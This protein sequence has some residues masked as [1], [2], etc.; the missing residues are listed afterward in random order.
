MNRTRGIIAVACTLI[1]LTTGTGSVPGSN[2]NSKENP[3]LLPSPSDSPPNAVWRWVAQGGGGGDEGFFR[4]AIDTSGNSYVTGV[5]QDSATF[6]K[7]N[8]TSKGAEDV[9]IAKMNAFGFWEWAVSAGGVGQD[10]GEGIVVD[11]DGTLYVVGAFAGT[12]TFGGFQLIS[13][14]SYDVFIAKLTNQGLWQWAISAGGTNEDSG[15]S[16]AIDGAGNMYITGGFRGSAIFGGTILT[17]SIDPEVYVA[18]ISADG[19]WQWAVAGNGTSD[20]EGVDIAVDTTAVYVLGSFDGSMT[21]GNITLTGTYDV[22]VACLNTSG[23]WQWASRGGGASF[24]SPYGFSLD[25][26][27]QAFVV[28]SFELTASFGNANITSLGGDDA[29]VAKIA[30]NGSW[31]WAVSAGGSGS[32]DQARSVAVDSSGNA[33]ISGQFQDT[34]GFGGILLTSVGSSDV[35]V[36]KLS[37]GGSWRW[38]SRAGSDAFDMGFGVAVE[39]NDWIHVAGLFSTVAVFGNITLTSRG[40]YDAFVAVVYELVDTT[41]PV[42]SIALNGTLVTGEYT[43]NVTVTLTAIDDMSGVNCTMVKVDDGTYQL[44][45]SPFNVSGFGNHTVSYFS[46]DYAGNVETAKSKSFKIRYPLSITIKNRPSFGVV[47]TIV[48]DGE[49]AMEAQWNISVKGDLLFMGMYR[50]GSRMI[51]AGKWYT[52]RDF[53]V[54]FGS[55]TITV[56]ANEVTVTATAFALA[57]FVVGVKQS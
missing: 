3:F 53:I 39:A 8:L 7:I 30:A 41:P 36:A 56:R 38:A 4:I 5:F 10:A 13:H 17:T 11:T 16:I 1:L 37:S 29:F 50:N 21:L 14:G 18:K 12:A 2:Q 20:D 44:Y 46:V 48:N 35:F 25:A 19:Q 9:V 43:T 51:P 47:A 55:I 6:G 40:G 54:G 57:I 32:N 31:L 26:A 34:I 42:T 45:H 27:G 52:A 49:V 23:G 28:G 22:F 33:V 24:D 15:R